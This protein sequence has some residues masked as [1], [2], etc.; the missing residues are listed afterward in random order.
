MDNNDF[1]KVL[2]FCNTINMVR[3]LTDDLYDKGYAV[4]CIYGGKSQAEEKRLSEHLKKK[5]QYACSY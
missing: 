5:T 2:V 3:M 1:Y 4:S